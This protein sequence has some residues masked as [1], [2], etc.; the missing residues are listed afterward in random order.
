MMA[1][2]RA[3]RSVAGVLPED[4]NKKPSRLEIELEKIY[5]KKRKQRK[6]SVRQGDALEQSKTMPIVVAEPAKVDELP[7]AEVQPLP[8]VTRGHTKPK[9]VVSSIDDVVKLLE[10]FALRSLERFV[11]HHE[12]GFL[13]PTTLHRRGF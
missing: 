7:Y 1:T 8:L 2:T 10:T 13:S 5:P 9:D 6:E 11:I 3:K 12:V 4:R